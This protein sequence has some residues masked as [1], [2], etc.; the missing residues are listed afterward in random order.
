MKSRLFI[1]GLLLLKIAAQSQLAV[2][3]TGVLYIKT[4]SDVFYTAGN[5]SNTSS[6][7][8]TIN[9]SLYLKGDVSNDASIN[10]GTG[11]V[12]LNGASTQTI[13]GA[14]PLKVYNL[15][16]NNAAGIQLNTNLIVTGVHTFSSGVITTSSTPNYVIY[17]SGSS[18]NGASDTRHI[19]GWIKKIGS[20]DFVFPSGDGIYLREIA[21]KNL[22]S[23]SEFDVRYSGPTYNPTN[24]LFPIVSV[25]PGEY[26][27]VNQITGGNAQVQLNWDSSKVP[28]PN[29][30]V[31]DLRAS[32]YSGA[33]LWTNAGGTASGSVATTGTITSNSLSSFGRIAIGSISF[34]LP[35]KF[36][37]ISATL[38]NN[39]A[40]VKW[41]TA[42]E[43]GVWNYS[44]QKSVDGINFSTIATVAALNKDLQSYEILDANVL[45]SKMYYRVRAND[46]DGTGNYSKIVVVT[47]D[48]VQRIQL[49]N[50]PAKGFIQLAT[51]NLPASVYSYRLINSL[52]QVCKKGSFS[53]EGSST[54][55]L[56]LNYTTPGQYTLV[57]MKD[58]EKKQFKLFI[59]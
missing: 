48:K 42:N 33:S 20:T 30:V 37:G 12:F 38:E 7:A 2:T 22:A 31:N 55:T 24:V 5:F 44:V 8:L 39:N 32:V 45:S 19:K 18:Y 58:G 35:L 13:N 59:Q 25:N 46:F 29:Y 41:Q 43:A 53:C 10:I 21:L 16:T 4:G 23:S 54:V 47:T 50:N 40:R 27:T 28:F 14:Q 11:T 49:I 9:G 51:Q 36:L 3:N 57:I 1:V 52:G 6:A 34:P 17:E 56:P 15:N 26:W